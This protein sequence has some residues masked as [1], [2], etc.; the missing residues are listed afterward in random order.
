MTDDRPA[1]SDT[2]INCGYPLAEIYDEPACPECGL[3]MEAARTPKPKHFTTAFAALMFSGL[4]IIGVACF[5]IGV[6]FSLVGIVVGLRGMRTS[7]VE[8]ERTLCRLA[9]LVGMI[10]SVITLAVVAVFVFA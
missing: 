5:P 6:V 8:T 1:T 3:D 9:A 7:E 2:C 10:S 4:G